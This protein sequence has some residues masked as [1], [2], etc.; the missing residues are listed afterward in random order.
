MG[1]LRLLQ[2]PSH[3]AKPKGTS[4]GVG[5]LII[6]LICIFL[7]LM[8][9]LV[10]FLV[11]RRMRENQNKVRDLEEKEEEA[12]LSIYE[13]GEPRGV[14]PYQPTRQNFMQNQAEKEPGLYPDGVLL[15]QINANR[16]AFVIKPILTPVSQFVAPGQPAQVTYQLNYPSA[17]TQKEAVW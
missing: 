16:N 3:A 8:V 4:T 2:E 13:D 9:L 11:L 5:Y 14:R 12:N 6:A 15:A 1:F 7:L 17:L 10:G